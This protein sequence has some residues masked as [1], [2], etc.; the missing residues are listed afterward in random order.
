MK[1]SR[2]GLFGGVL[3]GIANSTGISVVLLRVLFVVF[4][5][6]IGNLTLGISSGVMA[7]IYFLFWMFMD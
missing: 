7:L 5:F 2:S 6:G 4:F 3:A 1:R